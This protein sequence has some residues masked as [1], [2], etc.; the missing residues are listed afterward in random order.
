MVW[1]YA[2]EKRLVPDIELPPSGGPADA[3]PDPFA[4]TPETTQAVAAG[5]LAFVADLDGSVTAIRLADGKP[6]WRF[7]TP[8]RIYAPPTVAEGRVFVGGG[9]GRIYCLEATTGRELWRCDAAPMQRRIMVY[10]D[11]VNTWPITGGVVVHDSTVYAIAGLAGLD[12]TSVVALDVK[13][14]ALRW[15][16]DAH[17]GDRTALSRG[18]CGVGIP[19]IGRG[20]L[21]LRAASYDL[22][23]GAC[24]PFPVDK[25]DDQL[26]RASTGQL[27]AYTGFFDGRYLV[28]GGRRFFDDPPSTENL[29]SFQVKC[30]LTDDAGLGQ[31]PDLYPLS[32]C[33][34]PPAWS[35]AYFLA[36]PQA[37]RQPRPEQHE[38]LICWRMDAARRYLGKLQAQKGRKQHRAR[39]PSVF[40]L[41]PQMGK[42]GAFD[43]DFQLWS[44]DYPFIRAVVL[45]ANAAVAAWLEPTG[46]P[47]GKNPSPPLKGFL[48]AFRPD[49]G[50]TLWQV[51]LPGEPIPD[52][53]S[54]TRRSCAGRLTT[55]SGCAGPGARIWPIW[56]RWN[57]VSTGTG[58]CATR[59][60]G[61]W[62]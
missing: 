39:F 34:V 2:P 52:G 19:A 14:G 35:E 24:R 50:E 30:L 16:T 51:E 21:W 29:A 23:T 15:R 17:P 60:N 54:M 3:A 28:H 26:A 42:T 59:W 31:F 61:R 6:A 37:S 32:S 53:S 7:F 40:G 55:R 36:F 12:G 1:R 10:G 13:T 56:P 48:A 22:A 33:R 57:C 46:K 11:L 5:E 8:C 58:G 38:S 41:R 49:S 47:T 18:V 4:A 9:D 45:S 43:T 25:I 62:I 27:A 20:R 44:K